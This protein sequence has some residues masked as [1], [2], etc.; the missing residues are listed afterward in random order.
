MQF[1]FPSYFQAAFH[2]RFHYP[3]AS[4][5]P[6]SSLD[7]SALSFRAREFVEF[8]KLDPSTSPRRA[9]VEFD[10]LLH[11]FTA[12]TRRIDSILYHDVTATAIAAYFENSAA[13]RIPQE[14]NHRN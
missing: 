3:K 4:D 11:R 14:H 5:D 13:S 10:L 6:H 7:L 2:A 9:V 8:E 1:R 12:Q